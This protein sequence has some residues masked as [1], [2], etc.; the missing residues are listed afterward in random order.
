MFKFY[1]ASLLFFSSSL[2][3]VN[4]STI[5]TIKICAENSQWF[6]YIFEK[7]GKAMGVQVEVMTLALKAI[8]QPYELKLI[9]WKRCL[10]YAKEGIVDALIGA[11]YTK[12][13]NS[14]LFYP[15]GAKEAANNDELAKYRLADVDYTIISL[16]S[17][18]FNYTGNLKNIPQPILTPAGYAIINDFKKAGLDVDDGAPT[19]EKN[20]EKL[21]QYQKGSVAIVKAFATFIL[22]TK[23]YGD[24]LYIS[25]NSIKVKSG[26]MAF[27]RKGNVSVKTREK[28]WR[29]IEKYRKQHIE[30]LYEKYLKK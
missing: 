16:Q 28:I 8:E 2:V 3:V 21:L 14:Y 6:P 7:N 22:H 18:P 19:D 13:R 1:L 29:A 10:H 9:P 24:L 17:N 25:K 20:I 4:A 12:E 15:L 5:K 26:F 27:S 11:S 30:K 23:Q